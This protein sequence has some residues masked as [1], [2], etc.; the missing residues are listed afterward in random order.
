MSPDNVSA[1]RIKRLVLQAGELTPIY[2][3]KTAQFV[4]ILNDT[5][6]DVQVHTNT[7]ETEYVVITKGTERRIQA[8]APWFRVD[9]IAFWLKTANGGT[10]VIVWA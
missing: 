9:A 1:I 5:N 7:D 8:N 4:D 2:P 6:F 3:S 10:V